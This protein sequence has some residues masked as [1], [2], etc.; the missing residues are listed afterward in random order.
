[1]SAAG[2]IADEEIFRGSARVPQFADVNLEEVRKIP[3]AQSVAQ[4]RDRG[5]V[6]GLSG[7]SQLIPLA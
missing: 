2:S 4:V 1:M 3:Q 6:G 7:P 5:Q